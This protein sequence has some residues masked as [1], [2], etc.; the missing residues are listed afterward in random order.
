MDNTNALTACADG[1][2]C[3]EVTCRLHA[4]DIA[5]AAGLEH[6]RLRAKAARISKAHLE[7]RALRG[8]S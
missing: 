4:A 2:A 8:L 7:G 6:D 1:R 3:I 5:K